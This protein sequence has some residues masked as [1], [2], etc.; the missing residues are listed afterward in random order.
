MIQLKENDLGTESLKVRVMGQVL[1][2]RYAF[3]VDKWSAIKA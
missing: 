1:A 3:A 2:V